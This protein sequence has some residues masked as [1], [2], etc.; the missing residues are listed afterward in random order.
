M[1]HKGAVKI[2]QLLSICLVIKKLQAILMVQGHKFQ[3]Q[4]EPL[5]M[6]L[7]RITCTSALEARL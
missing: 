3:A 5:E 6:K 2:K 7:Y 4:L 1:I